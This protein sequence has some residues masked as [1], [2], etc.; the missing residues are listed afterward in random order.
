MVSSSGGGGAPGS[1]EL[2]EL[3]VALLALLS[4]R[5]MT[6]Y[7]ILRHHARALEPWWETPRTQIYPKLREL[8]KRGLIEHEFVV[9]ESKPNKR[10]YSIGPAGSQALASWLGSTIGV[11]EMRHHMMMRLFLGNLLPAEET[12]RLLTA[13]RDRM[14]ARAESFR[15]ARERFS[16]S[17][18]GPYRDSV[19]FELLSLDHLIALTDLEVAGTDRALAA[20][21][22][23]RRFSSDSADSAE[24]AS[25]EGASAG[26]ASAEQVS[27]LLDAIRDIR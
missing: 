15:Q 16:R 26:G 10:L 17:L 4:I 23:L 11:P 3:E 2:S 9:Q 13:Y 25:T 14:A 5:P 24:G 18:S 20:L 21:A 27:E 22:A 8:Q 19:F 1:A 12:S 6:G 7:E